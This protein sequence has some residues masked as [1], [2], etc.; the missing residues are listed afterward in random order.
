MLR[1]CLIASLG[2]ALVPAA[3]AAQRTAELTG[4]YVR[5]VAISANGVM[6]A[7]DAPNEIACVSSCHCDPD[8]LWC[9]EG[10]S[11]RYAEDGSASGVTCDAFYP[12]SVETFTVV[13]DRG[14]G[15]SLY[16][17][18]EINTADVGV[19]E[20][21][22]QGDRDIRW[23][24]VL[25]DGA[26]ADALRIDHDWDYQPDDRSVHLTTIVTNVGTTPVVDL[27]LLRNADPNFVGLC[28]ASGTGD[29]A[30][31][32]DVLRQPPVGSDALVVASA[33]GFVLGIGAHDDRARVTT[34]GH[35]NTDPVGEWTLPHDGGGAIENVAIDLIFHAT[36]L[37]PGDSTSFETFY[38]WGTSIADVTARFDAA[39][40]GGSTCVG[41]LDGVGCS[42][43][44]GVAGVCHASSCC[45]GCWDPTAGRCQ[46]GTSGLRC[47]RAGAN[48]RSCAD[49][50]A[51]TSD[52]CG[53]GACSNPPAPI[54]TPCDDGTFCTVRDVCDALGRCVSGPTNTCDDG[55]SCTTDRCDE[56]NDVCD[57]TITTGCLVGG[58]CVA[59]GRRPTAYPCLVCDPARN[60]TDW[61]A[62]TVGDGCRAPRCAA[63]AS[64]EG[65]TCDAAGA[66]VSPSPRMCPSGVCLSDA[67]ACEPPC[68]PTSCP[69]NQRCAASMHCVSLVGTGQVCGADDECSSGHCTDGVCC[70]EACDGVC[71]ACD[72]PH[73]IGRCTPIPATTDPQRECP[74][75]AVCDGVGACMDPIVSDAATTRDAGT[76]RPD[77]DVDGGSSPP[78]GST[79]GCSAPGS[80]SS[81]GG[82]P[83]LALLCLLAWRR[84]RLA[85]GLAMCAALAIPSAASARTLTNDFDWDVSESTFETGSIGDG[86]LNAY[87]GCYY[88][89][90][91][92]TQYWSADAAGLSLSGRQ[93]DFAS[94]DVGSGLSAERHVYVPGGSVG[95]A[96]YVELVTNTTSVDVTTTITIDGNLGSDSSTVLVATSSGDISLT[97][98]DRWFA[99]DDVDGAGNPSL[100]HVYESDGGVVS[101]SVVTLG[102]FNGDDITY[103]WNVTIPALGRIGIL[104]FAVQALDQ[105]TAQS[106]AAYLVTQPEEAIV[107]LD[108]WSSDIVNWGLAYA[109]PCVGAD[110]TSCAS[111]SGSSGV[112]RAGRCCTGCWDGA[113]CVTGR[114]PTGC[115]VAG[116]ACVRCAAIAFCTSAMCTAGVCNGSPCDDQQSCTTDTCDEATDTCSHAVTSGCIVGG[117]CVD[118]HAHHIAYPCLVC[119]SARN[120]VDWSVEPAGTPCGADR[121]SDG[122]VFGAG[123]CNDVGTCEAPRPTACPSM[124]CNPDRMTCEPLCTSTSCP[125]GTRCGP[126]LHCVPVVA[127]GADCT[128]DD[129]CVTGRCADGLCCDRACD[130]TCE[131]CDLPGREGTCRLIAAGTDPASECGASRTCDG[132]GMCAA[133]SADA[134]HGRPDAGGDAEQGDA[135]TAPPAALAC[136]C[137]VPG[138][139][140]G[141]GGAWAWVLGVTMLLVSR[142]RR[143]W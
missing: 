84:R 54:A 133:Q 76:A 16:G 88:L 104:H 37:A 1:A 118:E 140:G 56:T 121:C 103:T 105:A 34:G 90:V 95:W 116:G 26:G 24:G 139:P 13:V 17:H 49:G 67:T 143:A 71:A 78:S 44:A 87:D 43:A 107:G 108:D 39:G 55:A 114:A 53:L 89:T 50:D 106:T 48:C 115:G 8:G 131:A 40:S 94:V 99:T 113:R 35:E 123:T 80:T 9:V 38:V 101:P 137:N 68:T 82:L 21:P 52:V 28:P 51:C 62:V 4:T 61:S 47:G 125:A 5:Y 74:G 11:M 93:F 60:T 12:S 86:T 132:H 136:G 117:E 129:Q 126:L 31:A 141:D 128:S 92:T 59:D 77:A 69:I 64:F 138:R 45:T 22:T 30:T 91:G 57:H 46:T 124:A 79:C 3:A 36:G 23:A 72:V 66:C 100:A 83:M 25:V 42:S 10:R 85:A 27:Y 120:G 41:V 81:M 75:N 119:D 96:R 111:P 15:S 97:T 20:G 142:R 65:G 134:G 122:H 98:S 73:S 110:G 18:N 63:G 127:M 135:G 32:N 29:A 7:N 6:V 70:D 102:G 33:G 19:T 2:V 130:G 109:G 58:E 14:D 112:C